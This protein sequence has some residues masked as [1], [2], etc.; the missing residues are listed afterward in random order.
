MRSGLM[1]G[2][3]PHRT[4]ALAAT[5]KLWYRLPLVGILALGFAVGLV[6][7]SAWPG[8]GSPAVVV[9]PAASGE[10]IAPAGAR[11][12]QILPPS[13][14]AVAPTDARPRR[15]YADWQINEMTARHPEP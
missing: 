10:D 12:T 5:K 4:V 3:T 14:P 9:R 13:G 11:A 2:R 15:V 1:T 8:H 6:S 7:A